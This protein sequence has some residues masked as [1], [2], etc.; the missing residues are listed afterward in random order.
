MAIDLENSDQVWAIV[1]YAVNEEDSLMAGYL[2][3]F[4]DG[5]DYLDRTRNGSRS[6]GRN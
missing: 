3:A 2:G 4:K 6:S 5:F 1:D